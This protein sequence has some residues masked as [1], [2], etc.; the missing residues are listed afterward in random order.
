MFWHCFLE[1]PLSIDSP[2]ASSH[3]PNLG[4]MTTLNFQIKDNTDKKGLN[5]DKK[6]ELIKTLRELFLNIH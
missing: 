6:Q 5:S 3:I 2:H 1:G 4:D